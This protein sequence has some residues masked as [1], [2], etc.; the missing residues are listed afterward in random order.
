MLGGFPEGGAVEL[1]SE[2]G[3]KLAMPG[4][5]PQRGE[6]VQRPMAVGVQER[7]GLGGS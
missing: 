3:E 2:D 4:D 6:Q 1:S 7:V 5:R